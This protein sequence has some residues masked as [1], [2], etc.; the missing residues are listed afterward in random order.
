MNYEKVRAYA[1]RHREIANRILS[2][3]EVDY[4]GGDDLRVIAWLCG[5]VLDLLDERE[6][7]ETK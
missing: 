1:E 3:E 5:A 4:D 2:G 6:R 7:K